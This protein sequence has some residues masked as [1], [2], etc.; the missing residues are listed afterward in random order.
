MLSNQELLEADR[1]FQYVCERIRQDGVSPR[2][3]LFGS[4]LAR[5][6]ARSDIA[7]KIVVVCEPPKST[8]VRAEIGVN[9]DAL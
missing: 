4:T 7:Y 2:S 3:V 1:C 5:W 9:D 8:Y 6:L